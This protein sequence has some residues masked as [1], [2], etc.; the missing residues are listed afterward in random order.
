MVTDSAQ[1]TLNSLR[2]PS[3]FQWYVI[4]LFVIVLYIYSQEIHKAQKEQDWSKVAA[5][6]A[7]FGMDLIN[8][9]VNGLIFHFSDHAALWM[10]PGKSAYIILIGWNIEI[11][12]MFS[13]LGIAFAYSL[14]LNRELSLNARVFQ[15]N[16]RWVMAI[17]AAWG[18]VLIEVLLNKANVLVWEYWF[19]NASLKGIWLIFFLGYLHFY[20][21]T[22]LI[23]D[24]ESKRQKFL[25]L[26][27]IYATGFLGILIFG[28]FL[29]WL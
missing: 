19:W 5:G 1:Q 23:H 20:V 14:P 10:T 22:F 8:E 13:V 27:V 2:D 3:N 4:P 26:G 21:V 28:L 29:N 12:L 18:S 16:N 17:A 6:L 24:M 9:I 11:A 7:L 15:I 25:S